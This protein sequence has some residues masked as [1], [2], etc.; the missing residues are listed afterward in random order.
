[1]NTPAMAR[2]DVVTGTFLDGPERW[3]RDKM[4]GKKV[5]GKC[6][7]SVRDLSTRTSDD[8]FLLETCPKVNMYEVCPP[9]CL[10]RQILD[11]FWTFCP[12]GRCLYLV[13]LSSACPLQGWFPL[14][15][16]GQNLFKDRWGAMSTLDNRF[17]LGHSPFLM[18]I[19]SGVEELTQSSLNRFWKRDV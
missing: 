7:R 9:K 19:S 14:S 6:P 3:N 11:M 13:T 1:M 16:Y 15:N 17:W 5:P 12:F 8:K 18:L 10:W 2:P 4:W